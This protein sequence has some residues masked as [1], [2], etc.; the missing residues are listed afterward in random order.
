MQVSRD[1]HGASICVGTAPVYR[2]QALN[3]N[4][5]TTAIEHSEDVHTGFDLRARGW[6]L[7]YIPVPLAA[8]VCPDDPESFLTQQYRWCAGSMSLLTSRKFWATRMP[9]KARTCYLPGSV[10]TCIQP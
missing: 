7:R 1:A 2:R 4:G 5:G 3:A 8:G 9:W 6:N 10:T